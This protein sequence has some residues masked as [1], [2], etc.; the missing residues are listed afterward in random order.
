MDVSL[1]N[2]SES[3]GPKWAHFGRKRNPDTAKKVMEL[4][5]SERY[6]R[7]DDGLSSKV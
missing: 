5:D 6:R 7:T 3:L 1:E 2:M 4:L